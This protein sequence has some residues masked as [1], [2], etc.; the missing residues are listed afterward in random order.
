MRQQR[1]SQLL[2]CLGAEGLPSRTFATPSLCR[3]PRLSWSETQEEVV[4]FTAQRPSHHPEGVQKGSKINCSLDLFIDFGWVDSPTH[5]LQTEVAAIAVG[6]RARNPMCWRDWSGVW[7]NKNTLHDGR[8]TGSFSFF[9]VFS[10]F[11]WFSSLFFRPDPFSEKLLDAVLEVRNWGIVIAGACIAI[12]LAA[13]SAKE[14]QG[15]SAFG[16]EHG[17]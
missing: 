12:F 9:L 10:A 1:G 8:T 17:D 16:V 11:F 2:T 4:L 5:Q 14:P 15:R 13:L 7:I 6:I 3:W